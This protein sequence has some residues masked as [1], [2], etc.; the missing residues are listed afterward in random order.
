MRMTAVVTTG[1]TCGRRHGSGDAAVW[2]LV[3]RWIA[4]AIGQLPINIRKCSSWRST[5]MRA[6]CAV[7]CRQVRQKACMCMAA[8]LSRRG[9]SQFP[10]KS[11]KAE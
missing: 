3:P 9:L 1:S 10:L 2:R 6:D 8:A 5:L 11:G 7:R 4:F